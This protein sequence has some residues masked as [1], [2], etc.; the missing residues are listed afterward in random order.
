MTNQFQRFSV[1]PVLRLAVA[2][3]ALA[4]FS[5]FA[6][7]QEKIIQASFTNN[8]QPIKID[9]Q[10]GQSR[11]VEFDGDYER[12]AI[13]DEKVAQ[14]IPINFRQAIVNGITFGQVN[15]VA[16]AKKKEGEPERLV[17]FDIYV[18]TNLSLI[19]NQI[20]VLFPKENI[21]LSQVNNSVVLS[22]SVTKPELADQ[23]Q[24]IIEAAGLKVTNL[25]KAPVLDAAQVQLQI[26]VAE[27]NRSV[28]REL[29]T[30]YGVGNSTIPTYISSGGPGGGTGDIDLIKGTIAAAAGAL[31]GVNILMGNPNSDAGVLGFVRA[32]QT[33]GAI[34][35]LAEPNLIAM[36]G[37][38]ANF[39]AGGEFP[40]P[41]LQSVNAGQ[42]TITVVWKEFGVRLE[43][44]PTIIDENHIR[45]E[46]APEVSSLDFGSGVRV[47]DLV[48]P[49]LR[50]RRAK[51]TLELRDGQSFALAGLIDNN[52]QVS[53]S[54]IPLLADIPI[55]GEL[56]KS[57]RFQ[58]NETELLFLATV[59]LVEP[60]N[61][62]QL[63]RLPGV[64][65]LKPVSSNTTSSPAGQ[66]EGQSG[67]SVQR[68]SGDEKFEEQSRKQFNEEK[69][70][71]SKSAT[72][73][74]AKTS[75]SSEKTSAANISAT[76]SSVA[77]ATVDLAPI[78]PTGVDV[79]VAKN[80]KSG[81]AENAKPEA[82]KSEPKNPS[83]QN[84]EKP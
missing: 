81:K 45:L 42:S 12:I 39:L 31:S 80:G 43:F 1:Q 50:T 47:Q 73:A 30:A 67:H 41:V 11:V 22:G 25:L 55:L 46:L 66:V 60:L 69:A 26:R 64:S 68:K 35:E 21:Q 71:A 6:N 17:A 23:V 75:V 82:E 32:L 5:A 15:L 7:A 28:L 70:K 3:L 24:K 49:G 38:K 65:E 33:R 53:L 74:P 44:T 63:P 34:R 77:P 56:F 84:N 18:L 58:R 37:Q 13:S 27:V 51:T 48:I 52:E 79:P 2:V 8:G 62:D 78:G 76:V 83:P 10:V 20:K 4:T 72:V 61:P 29:A 40:V 16:W 54:K 14:V 9:V 59:K 19:D 36:H 57:R